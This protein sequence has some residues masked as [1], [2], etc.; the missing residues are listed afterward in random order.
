[1]KLVTN[2]NGI[3]ILVAEIEINEH[4]EIINKLYMKVYSKLN[5]TV[6]TWLYLGILVV[7]NFSLFT[8]EIKD[9]K[10]NLQI[11]KIYKAMRNLCNIMTR[12]SK[13]SYTKELI[14]IKNAIA[15]KNFGNPW[16]KSSLQRVLIKLQLMIFLSTNIKLNNLVNIFQ[17]LSQVWKIQLLN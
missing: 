7:W 1:M 12:K 13:S 15:R 11:W 10:Q 3:I 14:D 4:V 5:R 9:S 2:R 16:K 17:K 8:S 6:H